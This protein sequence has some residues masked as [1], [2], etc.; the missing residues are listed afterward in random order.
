MEDETGAGPA[1]AGRSWA[2][3]DAVQVLRDARADAGRVDGRGCRRGMQRG[4]HDARGGRAK[5]RGRG[6]DTPLGALT[7]YVPKLREGYY[8][9]E[10]I[11]DEGGAWTRTSGSGRGDAGVGRA[12]P[13]G[14]AP[15]H[16]DPV[17]DIIH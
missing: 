16:H 14:Q 11:I 1:V 9:P 6:L 4:V 10:N 2:A 7:V 8:S 5:Q 12:Y 15:L 17:E 13:A 3:G